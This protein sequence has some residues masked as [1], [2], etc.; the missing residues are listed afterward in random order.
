[1]ERNEKVLSNLYERLHRGSY[2]NVLVTKADLLEAGWE[3]LLPT[4]MYKVFPMYRVRFEQRLKKYKIVR[5]E[6]WMLKGS[7]STFDSMNTP[8]PVS[9]KP[10]FNLKELYKQQIKDGGKK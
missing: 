3:G 4:Q 8:L 7:P 5:V 10:K 9:V 2:W 6:P 1:M